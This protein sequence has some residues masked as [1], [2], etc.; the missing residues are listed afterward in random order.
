M[1]FENPYSLVVSEV[2]EVSS[3]S[4]NQRYMIKLINQ[5]NS[6]VNFIFIAVKHAVA[7]V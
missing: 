3:F 6:P 7:L 4:N 2:I 1:S 5:V